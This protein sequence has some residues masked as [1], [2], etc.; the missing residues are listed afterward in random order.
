[1]SVADFRSHAGPAEFGEYP[2]LHAPFPD[3]CHATSA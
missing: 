1:M 3:V 2:R